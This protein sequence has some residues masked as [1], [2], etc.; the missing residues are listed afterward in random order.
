MTRMTWLLLSA[1]ALTAAGPAVA[2]DKYPSKPVKILVPYA[3]GGGTDITARLFGDQLKNSL[4]QQF[5]IENKPGAF[6]ILAIEEMA[7]AKPDGYTLMIG[8]VST[9]AITPVLFKNKFK[10]DFEKEVQSVAR[11]NIYPSFLIATTTNFDVKDVND[12]VAQA[13]KSPGKVRYT[14]AGVGS[15]PHFDMEIFA[16]RAGVEMN[17]IPN[18]AGAAGMLNDLVVGDA[19]VA[20][21]NSA[22]SAA[23]IKAGKLKPLAVV[24]EQRVAGYPDVPTMTEA[25]FKSVGT[26]HWQSMLAPAATPKP[27]IDTL[28]KAIVEASKQ[29]ALKEAFDKQL[30]SLKVSESPDEAKTWLAGEL[31]SWRKITS[32]V[33][34]DLAE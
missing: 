19:Q 1:L 5:V 29:P 16:R 23:M 20:I 27:V 31:D 32:E 25:G 4:G 30:V 3:P 17:H 34:I 26:L 7:R 14:S 22:S 13:K 12:L 2:Q 18:K 10:I 24:A 9:N 33:K 28:F 6:G 15:F 8:N 21:I 11:F